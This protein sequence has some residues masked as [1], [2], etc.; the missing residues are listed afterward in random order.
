MYEVHWWYHCSVT[1]NNEFMNIT[2]LPTLLPIVLPQPL[3]P[4]WPWFTMVTMDHGYHDIATI[5]F[6]MKLYQQPRAGQKYIRF[7]IWRWPGNARFSTAQTI[8]LCQFVFCCEYLVGFNQIT[9]FYL[10]N[11]PFY[12]ICPYNTVVVRLVLVAD[13]YIS[14]TNI[15]LKMWWQCLNMV[16]RPDNIFLYNKEAYQFNYFNLPSFTDCGETPTLLIMPRFK[17]SLFQLLWCKN[18]PSSILNFTSYLCCSLCTRFLVV[19]TWSLSIIVSSILFY[20][21][22]LQSFIFTYFLSRFHHLKFHASRPVFLFLK[23][24]FGLELSKPEYK[25]DSK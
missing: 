22:S 17:F 14:C 10:K 3:S 6:P 23:R 13:H 19:M 16:L 24:G 25:L 12:Q 8:I 5:Y 7:K 9:P 15:I 2:L 18:S 1:L 20:K 11:S 21:F 4:L